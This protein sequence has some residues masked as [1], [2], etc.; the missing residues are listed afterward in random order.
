MIETFLGE[1]VEVIEPEIGHHLLKL[2]G[3]FDGSQEPGFDGLVD[4][5]TGSLTCLLRCLLIATIGG[6]GRRSVFQKQLWGASV[7]CFQASEF[8]FEG[9]R[10]RN[11]SWV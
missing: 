3:A 8:C 4:D 1:D 11:G 7:Y 10:D 9:V 6:V 5:N 2:S